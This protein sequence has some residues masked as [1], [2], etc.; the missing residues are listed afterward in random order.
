MLHF[1]SLRTKLTFYFLTVT[2]LS[3]ITV[4]GV[5][6]IIRANDIK[7]QEFEKLL[8]SRD[9][10][11]NQ[12]ESWLNERLGD[13]GVLACDHSV[14]DLGAS[15]HD[16]T[17][18]DDLVKK[19]FNSFL[20]NYNAYQE[21][22][23]IDAQSGIIIVS[24]SAECEHKDKSS[25]SYL[26]ET[27]RTKHSYVSSIYLSTEHQS[28][29]KP[30][31]A[32][33]SP[34]FGLKDG[35]QEVVGVVVMLV[36][37]ENMLFPL[38]QERT[39]ISKTGE[40]L[41]VNEDVMA[42]N[43]LRW[44]ENAPLKMKI[45][46]EPAKRAASGNT[47]IIESVDYRGE[48]VLAAFSYI[49]I[50]KWGLVVKRDTLEIYAPIYDMLWQMILLLFLASFFVVIISF[51]LSR[52]IAK[53]IQ[54][55]NKT[56][57][58]FDEGKLDAR[59]IVQGNDEVASLA[60]SFNKMAQTLDTQIVI[61][62]G[63]SSISQIIVRTEDVDDF[64]KQVLSGLLELS[65]CQ[66]GAFYLL[67]EISS[68]FQHIA[69]VGLT[70]D[71][72][73]SFSCKEYEGEL[74]KV[75]ATKSISIVHDIPQNSMFTY[76]TTVGD[77]IPQEIMTIPIVVE[78]K[79]AAIISLAGM[80]SFE[81]VFKHIIENLQLTMNIA[82]AKRLADARTVQLNNELTMNN[83][84]LQ[85]QATE[86][87]Q[88]TVELE[89]QTEEL[90][91]QRLQVE[92]ANR[93]KSEFLSNMSH[94]LRTPLNS[95]LS[96]SQLMLACNP[97][98]Q[99]PLEN[100]ERIVIIERNGRRLLNLI[101]DI[102]DLSKI[103]S[104]KMEVYATPFPIDELINPVVS[105]M[106][107]MTTQ[108]NLDLSVDIG[109]VE[110]LNTDKDK[111]QQ[112]LLNLISNAQK[113]TNQGQVGIRVTQA[114]QYVVFNIWDTGIG[115]P[116]YALKTIFDEFRQ[117][118]GSTTRKYGGTGLG[119]A[120][121]QRLTSLLGGKISVES[122]VDVGTTFT[123]TIP[124]KIENQNH[125]Q[126][127]ENK[128]ADTLKKMIPVGKIPRILV[129]ED[130]QV[131]REQLK[132]VLTDS[133]FSVDVAENGEEGL[134]IVQ[135]NTPDA[136][137]LDLMMPKVDGFEVVEV[138][139]SIS[140]TKTLPVL[141]LTAKD[142]SA[143]ERA[144]LSY[145][146]VQQLI[147]KGSLDREQLVNAVYELINFQENDETFPQIEKN[148]TT[149]PQNIS[150]KKDEKI[151][152][153]VVDDYEDNLITTVAMLKTVLRDLNVKIYEARDGLQAIQTAKEKQPHIIFMDIQMPNMGGTEATSIIKEIP[154][155]KNTIVIALTASAMS[156]DRE[157]II[158]AGCDDYIS[159][160]VEPRK[161]N[162]II[163]KWIGGNNE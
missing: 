39:G 22:F 84:E 140:K 77:I 113:F 121:C 135:E 137:I 132:R 120:I 83:S 16:S 71:S 109:D 46:A 17:E 12:I 124:I 55:I 128:V 114:G 100:Q 30:E 149:T 94:E 60:D 10:K 40:T 2:L 24:T 27:V 75:V 48:N 7:H 91:N 37:L 65:G 53:P 136:M 129:V 79:I 126:Y 127:E 150:V 1:K 145:N 76:K 68:S 102:L 159:K 95:V 4:V 125:I 157:A 35:K 32:L 8:I 59:C 23:Y 52:T 50:T 162:S 64:A 141:I 15:S 67:D 33:A 156:G 118:D 158:N 133:G 56:V 19:L 18:K 97:N 28:E 26:T 73:R 5:T 131:A 57:L 70:Q 119:L 20:K 31:M 96:L 78:D 69:S 9:L 160:P 85:A 89:E 144:K 42:L 41:I 107:P 93:L 58:K 154:E 138:I 21:I 153:L 72:T 105:L 3:I 45:N 151:S 63:V 82:L 92:Q 13:L 90:K 47:G 139:R 14:L 61:R 148:N 108:K 29:E 116:Q 134:K 38:I 106:K 88:Q 143:K 66:V 152:I 87:E 115:I 147:Q 101:N 111:L 112:I 104:G 117:V 81:D 49:P 155:L 43:E 99:D 146:N 80:S 142:I 34:V 98:E 62:Q 161:L 103:E 54:K 36:N 74:G 86:L 123:V 11:V 44:R 25:D 110:V 130:D 163:R 51:L 6:F 122:E